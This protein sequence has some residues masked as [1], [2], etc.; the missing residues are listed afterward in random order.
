MQRR[1]TE[2]EN[3]AGGKEQCLQGWKE[4]WN[5]FETGSVHPKEI[6]RKRVGRGILNGGGDGGSWMRGL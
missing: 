6:C 2:A 3:T 5:F 1:K 4:V